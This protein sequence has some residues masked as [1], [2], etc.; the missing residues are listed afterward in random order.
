MLGKSGNDD[1]R[2]ANE[3][4]KEGSYMPIT[5]AQELF[6]HELSEIYDAE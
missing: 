6:V 4:E 5:N 3:R 2:L 1:A